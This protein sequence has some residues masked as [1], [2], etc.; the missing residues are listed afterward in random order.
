MQVCNRCGGLLQSDTP[1]DV[2]DGGVYH[3]FCGWKLRRKKEEQEAVRNIK[4]VSD[5]NT[6]HQGSGGGADVRHERNED[7]PRNPES[8]P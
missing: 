1:R 7:T 3:I 2:F 5:A 6:L 8:S 4:G